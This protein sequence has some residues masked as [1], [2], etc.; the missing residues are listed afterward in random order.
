MG[1]SQKLPR[2]SQL[3]V[4][5]ES[6]QSPMLHHFCEQ[7]WGRIKMFRPS[8]SSCLGNHQRAPRHQAA[9]LL[10]HTHFLCICTLLSQ[11]F[12]KAES[13]SGWH[14][15]ALV[16]VINKV[17][18]YLVAKKRWHVETEIGLLPS[19]EGGTGWKLQT[20]E[21][22]GSCLASNSLSLRHPPSSETIL[23]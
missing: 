2:M 17:C 19:K 8:N 5:R 9:L 18:H 20:T 16:A 3:S 22:Q 13:S 12:V 11:L 10:R 1:T 14:S 6:C 23:H 4:K 7:R 21:V 15:D